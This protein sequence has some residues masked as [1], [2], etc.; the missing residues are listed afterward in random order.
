MD[1]HKHKIGIDKSDQ[2]L[3]Y[4]VFPEKIS[5]VERKSFCL[6]LLSVSDICPHTTQ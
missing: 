2:M 3:A 1:Y 5:K 6:S 4:V